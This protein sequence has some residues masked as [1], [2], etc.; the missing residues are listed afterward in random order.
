MRPDPRAGPWPVHRIFRILILGAAMLLPLLP[1]L[2]AGQ[3]ADS[4][5]QDLRRIG[6]KLQ[7]PVCEGTS[8]ADSRS[9]IA[10]DMRAVILA[11]L[12]TG[13]SEKQILAFFVDRY[14][15]AILRQPP[16]TGFYSVLWWLPVVVLAVGAGGILLLSRR[17]KGGA[18]VVATAFTTVPEQEMEAYRRRLKDMEGRP[19]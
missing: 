10:V 4:H 11:K 9:Q 15:P 2:V 3:D 14:G 13:E 5:G 19:S 8:V 17:R 7:C 18:T 12:A 6:N 1:Q 16:A